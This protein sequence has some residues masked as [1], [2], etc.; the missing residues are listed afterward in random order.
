MLTERQARILEFVISEY[1]ENAS[2]VASQYI[3]EKYPVGASSATIRNEMAELEE[4]GYLNQPHTSSGRVPTDRGYRF[5]VETLMHEEDLS[6]DAQQ[7]IRHQFHQ[8][9]HGQADWTQLAAA[10]LAQAVHNVALVT[11]PRTD[12]CRIKHLQLV[13]LHDY[14]ALLVLVLD[15][16]R[17]KQ[18]MLTLD[19]ICTQDQLSATAN[20]LNQQFA[21]F[22]AAQ[23]VASDPQIAPTEL[24]VMDAVI[25]IMSSIDAGSF[26]DAHLEGLRNV[27]SQPEFSDSE[28]V[29]GLLE[30]LSESNISRSIPLRSLAGGGVTVIIGADNPA[31]PQANEAMRACSVVVASYGS[32]GDASGALAVVGPTRM[33]YSHTISTVRYLASV[34]SELLAEHYE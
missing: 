2:P 4:Q 13:S 7:T 26:D 31:L 5:F 24:L 1:V 3:G 29:L 27:L 14:S 30:L 25:E 16:S 20:R 9:E 11:E 34:M 33:H 28:H 22:S 19:E 21:G 6:W 23:L 15:E 10:V 8:V 32:T 18:H 12:A 17:L